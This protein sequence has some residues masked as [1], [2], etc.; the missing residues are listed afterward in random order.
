MDKIIT[1]LWA[2]ASLPFVTLV[3]L[4]MLQKESEREESKRALFI[5]TVSAWMLIVVFSASGVCEVYFIVCH[6][7]TPAI[8]FESAWANLIFDIIGLLIWTLSYTEYYKQYLDK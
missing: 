2:L 3:L 1:V 4:F 6:I 8:P 5:K 7:N